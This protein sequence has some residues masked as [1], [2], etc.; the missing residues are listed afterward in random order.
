MLRQLTLCGLLVIAAGCVNAPEDGNSGNV[1]SSSH[2]FG[3]GDVTADASGAH[4]V[5]GS[6]HVPAG[7]TSGEVE[8]VNGSINVADGATL[9]NASTVNGSIVIGPKAS[10]A[11]LNTV[12]GAITLDDG[13]RVSRSVNSVNGALTLRGGS[14]VAGSIAN[15]NGRI[16]LTNAH[17]AGGIR[18]SNGDIDVLGN[19]RIDGDVLVRRPSSSSWFEWRQH[20]PRI[21]V[22]PGSTVLGKLRFER[23]VRLY[24]SDRATI[25]PV[26]GATPIRFAGDSPSG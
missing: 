12:N 15:V 4:T 22:G 17:V 10:A 13:A 7:Q 9:S 8:T 16:S 6:I 21:V 25:G 1:N 19:S 26:E 3:F 23:E 11:S 20:A 24:V 18:T 2:S 14:D 5:N